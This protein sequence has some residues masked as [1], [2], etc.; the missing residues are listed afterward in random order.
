MIGR[1]EWFPQDLMA[2]TTECRR[3][4][5]FFFYGAFCCCYGNGWISK[6]AGVLSSYRVLPMRR[7]FIIVTFFYW[8]KWPCR[9]VSNITI[10]YASGPVLW[11][12]AMASNW[13]LVLLSLHDVQSIVSHL[14]WSLRCF[15]LLH[16][17]SICLLDFFCFFCWRSNT[18][19][20]GWI[21]LLFTVGVALKWVTS[22][23][24]LFLYRYWL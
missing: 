10:I 3:W 8:N 7:F 17:A 18:V 2:T 12:S 20:N 6:S 13:Y 14:K 21:F 1:I 24:Q 19:T 4:L 11:F 15:T 16:Y 5:S 22:A 23:A 9:C